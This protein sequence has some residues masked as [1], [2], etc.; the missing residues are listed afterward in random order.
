MGRMYFVGIWRR[1][2]MKA[3]GPVWRCCVG[4]VKVDTRVL[5]VELESKQ[6]SIHFGG[7]MDKVG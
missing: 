6:I 3:G 1:L 5:A 4:E 7:R 2:R